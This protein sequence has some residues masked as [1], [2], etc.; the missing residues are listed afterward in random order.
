[1][2]EDGITEPIPRYPTV[3]EAIAFIEAMR[4][5]NNSGDKA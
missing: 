1:M 2:L 4:S 5:E 3:A